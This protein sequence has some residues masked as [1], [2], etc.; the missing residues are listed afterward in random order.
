MSKIAYLDQLCTKQ[1][2]QL[3]KSFYF[4]IYITQKIEICPPKIQKTDFFGGG[5]QLGRGEYVTLSWATCATA[6]FTT[7]RYD[8]W[9][10]TNT[11]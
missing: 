3:I 9:E 5:L 11:Y 10:Y 7:L 1:L 6:S 2:F 4:I 8:I